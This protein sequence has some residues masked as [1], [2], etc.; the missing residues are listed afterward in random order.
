MNHN[1]FP[2]VTV[3]GLP[4]TVTTRASAGAFLTGEAIERRGVEKTPFYATSA[5]AQVLSLCAR[6]SEVSDCYLAADAIH[7]DGMSVV[8]ASRLLGT[9]SLPERVATTDLFHDVA[10]V[11]Q[12][13]GATFYMLGAKQPALQKALANVTRMYPALNIVGARNGYFTEDEEEALIAEINSANPD[14]LWIGIG[15]PIAQRF[16]V[17]N[18][19]RLTNVGVIITCG[20]LFDFL[21]GNVPR[22]PGWMQSAG[23]EWLFRLMQEPRR[24]IARNITTNLHAIY[25][26]MMRTQ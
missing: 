19:A 3:G 17:R 6:N 10:K 15:V 12:Q 5:N 2:I 9:T 7:A 24:L 21:S 25:L 23:L 14:I 22:A 20:G 13:S 8:F 18:R 11:A 1:E 4:V 26:F 16:A